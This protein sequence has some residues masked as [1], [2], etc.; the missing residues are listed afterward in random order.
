MVIEYAERGTLR[1]YLSVKF[2]SLSWQDKYKLALQLS[3]AI[4]CLH[5]NGMVHKDL[6]S[7]SILI[8]QDS[9][10]LA[11]FGLSKRIKDISQISLNSFNTLPYDAP[12]G[13]NIT[14]EKSRDVHS[15]EGE[16][17]IEILKKM[18]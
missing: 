17:Q 9:I 4:E 10:K 1:S 14:G 12:E 18:I 11:D 3:D 8:Q 7:N 15:L 5:E 13:F 2:A 6:H 16:K